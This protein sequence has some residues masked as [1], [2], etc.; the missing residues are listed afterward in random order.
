MGF[1]SRLFMGSSSDRSVRPDQV[2]ELVA[3]G[4]I[5]VDVRTSAEWKAG[6]VKG[7]RHMPLTKLA[8]GIATLPSDRPIILAC[9]SGHRSARATAMVRARGLQG[10]NLV[11]GL[12]G[13]ARAGGELV[14]SGG[15]PGRVL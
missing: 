7:A 5:L 12:A 3:Q 15:R 11:G 4:A 8:A 2:P 6:H 10:I 1:L 9:R 14:A 13:W